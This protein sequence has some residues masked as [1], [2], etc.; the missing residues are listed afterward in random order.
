MSVRDIHLSDGT[1]SPQLRTPLES[2]AL[3]WAA[4]LPIAAG[5]LACLLLHGAAAALAL[6]LTVI[7]SGAVLCFLSGVRRGLSFR[8]AGGP[9]LSQLATMFWLFVLGVASLLSPWAVPSLVMQMLGY[10]TMA[11]YDTVD[12]R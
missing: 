6:R 12:A 1:E 3:A 5:A 10:A 9:L 11:V 8:Q 7:W 2:L 4:M